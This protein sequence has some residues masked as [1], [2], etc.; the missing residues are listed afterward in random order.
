MQPISRTNCS[1]SSELHGQG[2][3]CGR[4]GVRV[5]RVGWGGVAMELAGVS[6]G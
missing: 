5:M 4:V 1:P 6:I 3:R 2:M